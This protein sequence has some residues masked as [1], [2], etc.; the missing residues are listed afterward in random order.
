MLEIKIVN[1]NG[2]TGMNQRGH[3]RIFYDGSGSLVNDYNERLSG[4]KFN[5]NNGD[6]LFI[7]GQEIKLNGTK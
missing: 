1:K 3:L 4:T 7:N 6:K 5:L 2:E